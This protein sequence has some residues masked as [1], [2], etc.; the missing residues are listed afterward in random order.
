M[1]NNE[2]NVNT[3][4]LLEFWQIYELHGIKLALDWLD[5]IKYYE[6]IESLELNEISNFLN[7]LSITR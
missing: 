1:N 3:K 4:K 6:D 2:H 7:N 5:N